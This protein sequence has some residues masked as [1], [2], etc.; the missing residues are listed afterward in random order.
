MAGR[1]QQVLTLIR[2]D[3]MLPQQAIAAKLGISRSAVAGHI[4]N[5][6]HKGLIKGRGYVLSDAP[7]VVVIGGANIDIHGKSANPLQSH[8]SNP[9]TVHTSAGGVARNI[10][11]NLARLGI[12]SRLIS[13]VGNDH[14]GQMLIRMS[15]DAGVNMHY[16]HQISS[17]P[18]STYMSVLD[19]S[20][21]MSVAIN[22]MSII[23]ALTAEYLGPQK[24][25]LAQSS[26]MILDCN[27]PDDTLEWLTRSFASTPIF[28]DTV[29]A[30]KA[31]RIKSYLHSVHT[32]K[33]SAIEIAALTGQEAR[34]RSQLR[35]IATQLHAEGVER[36]FIT[37]GEQGVFYSTSDAQGFETPSSGK[38]DILSTGGA[39]DAF[40]AGLAYSWLEDLSLKKALR[41]A[42][43]AADITLSHPATN[44]PALSV[45][46]INNAMEQQ[47]AG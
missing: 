3:P 4:M 30:A 47:R 18:T 16:V 21:D 36:L 14:H 10:A 17:A 42:M 41:F 40:L 37:R 20:G 28:V 13:A 1:E 19:E 7:F 5:L 32:L 23:N 45:N 27:L 34:T 43:A 46:T 11:D 12:D 25:M 15:R 38:R 35:A 44:H 26:L 6:T 22:D 9:G 2:D 29:S 39:G 33:A 24:S 8:D 31:P